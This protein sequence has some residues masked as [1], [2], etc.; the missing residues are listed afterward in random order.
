MLIRCSRCQ[1]KAIITTRSELTPQFTKLYC[2]CTNAQCGHTFVM[3]LEFDHTL[4]PS[5]F[6]LSE[7]A[8]KA[9]QE[10]SST[11]HIQLRLEL[12]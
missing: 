11:R 9:L 1:T 2:V 10:C 7:A 3:N 12:A 4:S 5:A 8:R 6:D